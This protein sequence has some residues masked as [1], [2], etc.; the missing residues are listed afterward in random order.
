MTTKENQ[1]ILGF[2][3]ELSQLGD[4]TV[5]MCHQLIISV[6]YLPFSRKYYSTFFI[7]DVSG[8]VE[9]VFCTFFN[10]TNDLTSAIVRKKGQLQMSSL[11]ILHRN[12][13]CKLCLYYSQKPLCKRDYYY[14]HN[15]PGGE[16]YGCVIIS[17]SGV[18]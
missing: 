2:D 6:W 8:R 3:L 14:N 13:P 9:V 10:F 11:I 16:G 12:I 18:Y 17:L 4:D 5:L 15:I 7:P 1:V